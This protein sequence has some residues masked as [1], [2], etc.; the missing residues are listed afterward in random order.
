[1]AVISSNYGTA[2]V[3]PKFYLK[4]LRS[5]L[6][7]VFKT[8]LLVF[9]RSRNLRDMRNFNKLSTGIFSSFVLT[10]QAMPLQNSE[11]ELD[12]FKQPRREQ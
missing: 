2:A 8:A 1:M 10:I 5:C 7:K 9:P 6:K 4:C 12:R 3:W 11:H